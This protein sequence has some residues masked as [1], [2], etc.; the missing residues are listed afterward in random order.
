MILASE[1]VY[2]TGTWPEP[3]MYLPQ[4]LGKYFDMACRPNASVS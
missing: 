2:F 1:K 3:C 4:D